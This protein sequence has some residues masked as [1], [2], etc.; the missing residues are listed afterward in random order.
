[1]L[2]DS[3]GGTCRP[4]AA[5]ISSS[6]VLRC[7]AGTP[8]IAKEAPDTPD[9]VLTRHIFPFDGGEGQFVARLRKNG[10]S[11]GKGAC[12]ASAPKATPQTNL[13]LDFLKHNFAL[14]IPTERIV[15]VGE[16]V[17]ITTDCPSICAVRNGVFAGEAR[18]GRFEPSHALYSAYGKSSL[19]RV[20]L[21]EDSEELARYLHGDEIP[22]DTS[23]GFAAVLVDGIP[24][25]FGKVSDGKL[26]NHYPKGLR[27]LA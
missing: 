19:L 10:E 20:D 1:M 22:C 17:Y 25:S 6:V 24:L 14:E 15:S 18:Q 2:S 3:I 12:F 4:S 26:K 23:K 5:L 7:P 27:R 8:G 9:I 16:K 13:F 11:N 21:N